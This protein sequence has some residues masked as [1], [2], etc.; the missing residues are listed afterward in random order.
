MPSDKKPMEREYGEMIYSLLTEINGVF[1]AQVRQI[2]NSMGNV[3]RIM[4]DLNTSIN[5]LIAS[6]KESRDKRYQEEID[7]LE[8]QMTSLRK[9]LEQKKIAK[10]TTLTTSQEMRA[11]AIDVL[12]TKEQ[13][14]KKRWEIDWVDI[15]NKLV[16]VIITAIVLYALP[17]VGRFFATV[18]APK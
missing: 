2:N 7:N 4:L 6:L 1:M 5:N 9:E 17:Y 3:Q 12:D 16:L 8:T 18:F 15:R 14:K 11:I 10:N 13:E